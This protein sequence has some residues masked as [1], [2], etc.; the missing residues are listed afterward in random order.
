M[1]HRKYDES[2]LTAFIRAIVYS[3]PTTTLGKPQAS[4]HAKR[5][6]AAI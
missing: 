3:L 6:P 1:N 4:P 5:S 2:D